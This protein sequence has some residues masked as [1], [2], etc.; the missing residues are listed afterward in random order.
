MSRGWGKDMFGTLRSLS[1]QARDFARSLRWLPATQKAVFQCEAQTAELLR[2]A[3]S[4]EALRE[5]E[6]REMREVIARLTAEV[7]GYREEQRQGM[8]A[9]RQETGE[10]IA[11]LTAEVRG[12]RK[13]MDL[14]L[15]RGEVSREFVEA[16]HRWK[17]DHSY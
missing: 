6:R 17:E 16:F 5:Q 2:L 8:G 4:Y 10:R 14:L 11:Q 3:K 7:A 12:G 9:Q 13:H 15:S 1:R